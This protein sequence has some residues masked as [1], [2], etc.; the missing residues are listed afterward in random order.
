MNTQSPRSILFGVGEL[1]KILP[2]CEHL[3]GNERFIQ[4]ALALQEKLSS[5]F[6]I[7]CDLEDGAP[8]GDEAA[9]LKTIIDI[10]IDAPETARLGVRIHDTKHQF[11]K[12]EL[13]TLV[14]LAGK[15][16]AYIT[17]PKVRT[18][19]EVKLIIAE[20]ERFS[21]QYTEGRRIPL[22]VLIETP[23]ALAEAAQIAALPLVETLDFGLMDFISEHKGAISA[24]CMR[25]PLQFEHALLYRARCEIA[26]AALASAKVASH[27]VCVA[28]ESPTSARDDARRARQEFAFQRMWSIHPAQIEPIIEGMGEPFGE[29]E[30][31]KEIILRAVSEKWGPISFKN[32]LHDR[33]SY[34]YYWLVLE[35]ARMQGIVLGKHVDEL[36]L[37]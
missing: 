9:F 24:N 21:L 27:N 16:I 7:T 6:D 36:F 29:V 12:D 37:G 26:A 15:K 13:E 30:K 35:R 10:L 34:R 33:A 5:S 4:K 1:P 28:L 25:S 14:S 20:L 32:Q 8:V 23:T 22:H 18:V 19:A 17:V 2:C 31:A 11:F 3:A